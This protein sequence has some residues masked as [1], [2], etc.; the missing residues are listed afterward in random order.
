MSTRRAVV[1]SPLSTRCYICDYGPVLC[2]SAG[3]SL[4]CA[5]YF[6][7]YIS[8]SVYMFRHRAAASAFRAETWTNRAELTSARSDRQIRPPESLRRHQRSL[9]N[10]NTADLSIGT[11]A[12]FSSALWHI[13][14][15]WRLLELLMA[16]GHNLYTFLLSFE[17]NKLSLRTVNSSRNQLDCGDLQ[18]FVYGSMFHSD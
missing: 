18:S 5:L 10:T 2:R 8:L 14:P 1:T 16:I 9:W 7:L 15:G 12:E 17:P 6:F 4:T 11:Q 13:H 3:L